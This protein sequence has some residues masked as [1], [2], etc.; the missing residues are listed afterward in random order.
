MWAGPPGTLTQLEPGV[1]FAKG[2]IAVTRCLGWVSSV[3][4]KR[5]PSPGFSLLSS[6]LGM[7]SLDGYLGR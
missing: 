1:L 4:N 6:G 7:G 2:A 3:L 5:E